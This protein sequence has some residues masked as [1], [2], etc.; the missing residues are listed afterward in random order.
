MHSNRFGL[1][2]FFATR[3]RPHFDLIARRQQAMRDLPGVVGY[4]AALRGI[5]AGD[6]LPSQADSKPFTPR[7]L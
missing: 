5:L 6:D 1:F 3:R 2:D 4:S 7:M